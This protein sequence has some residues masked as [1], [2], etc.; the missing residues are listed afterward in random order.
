V[1]PTA[2]YLYFRGVTDLLEHIRLEGHALLA[3]RLRETPA[4]LDPVERLRAMGRAYFRFG[5]EQPEF[6][7]LMFSVRSADLPGRDAVQREMQTLLVVRDVVAAGIQS[8]AIRAGDPT[9]FANALWAE[10]HGVT[11]L[12]VS[13][14][15]FQTAPGH[16]DEVLETVL[17]SGLDALRPPR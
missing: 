16:A 9:V 13:G 4:D 14:L 6:Y 12:T 15:L 8:G 11:A 17:S 3:T 2:I 7:A 5:V 10:V 1:S